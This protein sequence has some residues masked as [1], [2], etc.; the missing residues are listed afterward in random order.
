MVK[1]VTLPGCSHILSLV[2]PPGASSSSHTEIREK[3]LFVLSMGS[4]KTTF[5]IS[6]VHSL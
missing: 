3:P 2:L 4:G 6:P 1:E 5:E